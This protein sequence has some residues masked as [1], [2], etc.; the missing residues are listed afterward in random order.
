MKNSSNLLEY[1]GYHA[2][3]VYDADS[4]ILH[5]KILGINDLVTFESDSAH[6]LMNE[7]HNAVDDYLDFCVEV[8]K[9]PSK[10][11]KGSLNIRIEPEV[12]KS[13]SLIASSNSESLNSCIGRAL[14]M[15]LELEAMKQ[16]HIKSMSSSSVEISNINYIYKSENNSV[17]S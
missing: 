5:G 13:I 9:E 6:E 1:K 14:K 3:V 12:H 16:V 8:G 2:S 15:Y 11:Y 4:L 17:V 10:E 7:F